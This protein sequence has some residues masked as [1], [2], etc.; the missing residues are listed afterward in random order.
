M[1]I[2]LETYFTLFGGGTGIVAAFGQLIIKDKRKANYNLAALWFTL[3]LL[4]FQCASVFTGYSQSH[5]WILCYHLTLIWIQAPLL[6][7]AY[8]YLVSPEEKYPEK[9]FIL[10]IPS[11]LAFI[12]DSASIIAYLLNLIPNMLWIFHDENVSWIAVKK[13]LLIAGAIQIVISLIVFIIRMFPAWKLSERNS[14]LT[15]TIG[16]SIS[17]IFATSFLLAGY[18][19]INISYLKTASLITSAGIILISLI[20]QRYPRF[21]QI[22]QTEVKKERYKKSLLAGRDVAP[23]MNQMISLMEKDYLYRDENLTLKILADRLSM[24]QHQLS[25]L[26]NDNLC[27]NFSNFINRYRITE[28][29]RILL[30]QP[31]RPVLAIAFDV[32]FNN[33]TSFYDAFSRFNGVSPHK[34]RKEKLR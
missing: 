1:F 22:L 13:Y 3:G 24:N 30:E 31:D 18:I 32:G 20:G 10:F 28:A 34:Y 6:Y 5:S 29:E 7:L 8:F 25:Q 12:L 21:L 26:L 14:I 19:T 9:I 16:Y 17:S 15:I 2:E 27:T 11:I 33:K 4:M 23:M